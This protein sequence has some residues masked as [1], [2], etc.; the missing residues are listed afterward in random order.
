[1]FGDKKAAKPHVEIVDM[2]C[3]VMSDLLADP[4]MRGDDSIQSWRVFRIMSEFVGGFELLRKYGTAA[5]FF[6]SARYDERH[7]V[8]QASKELAALLAQSGFAIITGGGGGV[9][10]AANNGAFEAGGES[11]GLN[12]TLPTEQK[13]NAFLTDV[14]EFHFFFSRKVMLAFASEVYVF[15]PG[16]YGTLD[17]LFELVTLIQTKKISKVPIV[18]IDRKYWNPLLAFLK[19]TVLEEYKGIDEADLELMHVVDSVEEAYQY[20]TKNVDPCSPRQI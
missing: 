12:I 14:M 4:S 9:M 7:P 2:H 6:G 19:Q 3:R 18:L 5:T 13:P 1:M 10:S 20:I 11:V 17:E 8:Y 16:G 15:F